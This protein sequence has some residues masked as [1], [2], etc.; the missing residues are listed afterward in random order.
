MAR[1]APLR[2]C[3]PVIGFSSAR[4]STVSPAVSPRLGGVACSL[5][6]PGLE[7][8]TRLKHRRRCCCRRAA[9]G[10]ITATPSASIPRSQAT[11][12]GGRRL[13][14]ALPDREYVARRPVAAGALMR[15]QGSSLC[16][17]STDVGGFRAWDRRARVHPTARGCITSPTWKPLISVRGFVDRSVFARPG[18]LG[19]PAFP[20][21][22]SPGA[23][24]DRGAE[25]PN[26]S[27][28]WRSWEGEAVC[29]WP[30]LYPVESVRVWRPAVP[31]H[32][33]RMSKTRP[34]AKRPRASRCPESSAR[35]VWSSG[36]R[37]WRRSGPQ[38]RACLFAPG[39]E[40]RGTLSKPCARPP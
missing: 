26:H 13:L 1:R 21:E 17:T 33:R 12:A 18:V 16:I 37:S 35:R 36:W 10:R 38:R 8:G 24:P 31:H 39:P 3:K 34:R 25:A 22:P 2:P 14:V 19:D 40:S 32:V 9:G 23:R 30:G 15:S 20:R 29:L 6:L 11:L 28:S 5:R 27:P 4:R 7:T